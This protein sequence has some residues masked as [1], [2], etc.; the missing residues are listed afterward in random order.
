MAIMPGTISG[1]R[2]D[3][4][5]HER[6]PRRTSQRLPKTRRPARS[7]AVSSSSS[8]KP[9]IER[10]LD[11]EMI[12]HLGY[13]KHSPEGRNSGNSRN[14]KSRKMLKGDREKPGAENNSNHLGT[15]KPFSS[16]Q[17]TESHKTLC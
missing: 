13:E 14:G 10:V 6:N 15:G 3:Y 17:A 8:P 11:G 9:Q 16:V 4:G 12:H 7:A 5:H 1:E 2:I